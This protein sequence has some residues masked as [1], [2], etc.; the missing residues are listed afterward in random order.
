[1]TGRRQQEQFVKEHRTGDD[2]PADRFEHTG[3]RKVRCVICGR[4]GYGP[5]TIHPAATSFDGS[6]RPWHRQ[7]S[8][9]QLSCLMPH[10]WPCSCGLAFRTYGDLWRHIGAPRP[11]GWGRAGTHQPAL[12]CE[13]PRQETSWA[14]PPARPA[15]T[16]A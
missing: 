10:D 16:P 6:T 3:G 2:L 1:M 4:T 8:P 7:A 12:A 14:P 13:W 5:A 15:T 11:D 9:W